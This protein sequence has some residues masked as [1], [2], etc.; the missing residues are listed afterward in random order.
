MKY[1]TD[2]IFEAYSNH[3]KQFILEVNAEEGIK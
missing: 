3:R 2:P 1:S